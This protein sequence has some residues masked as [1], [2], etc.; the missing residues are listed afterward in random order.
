M[1]N[2]HSVSFLAVP[3]AI[4]MLLA[5]CGDD[6]DTATTVETPGGGSGDVAQDGDSV[7]VHYTG[8]LDDGTEFDSSRDRG[9][10]AFVVG[11]GQVIP[12][13]DEAVRGLAA[14]ESRTVRIEPADAYGEV[15]PERVREFPRS[16]APDDI[17][18]GGQV[19]FANGGVGTVLEITD[20]V[21]R[22]DANHP[23]AGEALTFEIELVSIN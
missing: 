16:D 1:K 3:L 4:I 18:V 11:S 13:F 10:L 12:G 22:I 23:L 9:P 7:E 19:Q 21:V 2:R 20:E 14:G 5:A 17:A 15:D 8:T 6:D